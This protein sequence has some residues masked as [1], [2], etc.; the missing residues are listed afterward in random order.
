[1]FPIKLRKRLSDKLFGAA[2]PYAKFISSLKQW[3]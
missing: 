1:M 3:L 2:V